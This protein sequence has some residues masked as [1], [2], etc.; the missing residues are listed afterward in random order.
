MSADGV[1]HEIRKRLVAS[2]V[3]FVH[4]ATVDVHFDM[5]IAEMAV[6][7]LE[8]FVLT[9]HL[10]GETKDVEFSYEVPATWWD[11]YKHEHLHW[12]WVHRHPPR[13]TTHTQTRTVRF[14]RYATF[15]H[16]TIEVPGL[17]TQVIHEELT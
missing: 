4:R 17:G 2:V 8:T 9:E 1:L 6:A 5:M 12:G 11:H 16:S 3:P 15:P 14:D 10:V 13:Y 7:R